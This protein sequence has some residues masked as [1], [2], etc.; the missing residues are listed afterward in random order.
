MQVILKKDVVKIGKAGELLEVSDGYARNFLFPRNLA[1]E[2]TAGRIADLNTRQQNRKVK[3]DKEKQAAEEHRK[4]IQGKVV[5]VNASAGESGKLFGSVTTAQIA[6]ALLAQYALKVDKRYIKLADPV[7]QP[8][9][10]AISVKL[11]AG[12]QADM[13]L[14]VEIHNA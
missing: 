11:H 7:K 4:L 9:N 8:G 1:E 12:V 5:R 13:I 14:V 3:E 6:E 2:A 10:H